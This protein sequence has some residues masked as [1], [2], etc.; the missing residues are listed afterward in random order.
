M[1]HPGILLVLLEG[2][3]PHEPVQ[4][5]VVRGDYTG[6]LVKVSWL[7]LDVVLL[8]DSGG[9]LGVGG[10]GALDHHLRALLGHAAKGT[11]GVHQPK[12]VKGSVHGLVWRGEVDHN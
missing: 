10:P 6:C 2:C 4:A 3:K 5:V 11:I 9:V 1:N 12:W 7:A 8:P